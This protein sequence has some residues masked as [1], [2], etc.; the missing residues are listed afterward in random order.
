MEMIGIVVALLV[1]AVGAYFAG[2]KL[3][4]KD[5]GAI[6]RQAE[7]LAAKMIDD[8]RR[9]ADTWRRTGFRRGHVAGIQDRSLEL[10]EL[11]VSGR[12]CSLARCKSEISECHFCWG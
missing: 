9:E 11:H 8:A 2:N 3:N 5:S 12:L 10:M 4:K 6:V 7:E 1:V